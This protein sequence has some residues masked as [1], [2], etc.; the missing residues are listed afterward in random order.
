MIDLQKPYNGVLLYLAHK[1][2]PTVHLGRFANLAP[3]I[4][5][6]NACS[7]NLNA[8]VTHSNPSQKCSKFEWVGC[9]VPNLVIYAAIASLPTPMDAKPKTPTWTVIEMDAA[10]SKPKKNSRHSR[11]VENQSYNLTR[12]ST[13]I[14]PESTPHQP[15][16]NTH[17][18]QPEDTPNSHHANCTP[19][20]SRADSTFATPAIMNDHNH[21]NGTENSTKTKQAS[22]EKD[23]QGA[24]TTEPKN[25][26]DP[27]TD[28]LP[29]LSKSR[30]VLPMLVFFYFM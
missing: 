26:Y 9:V 29:Q 20:S 5:Y 13:P 24:S 3:G 30:Q 11:H 19:E 14:L 6:Q 27:E 1:E 16:S 17:F 23:I 12:E 15:E 10:C 7:D 21:G 8:T 2:S 4:K 25:L 22:Q 28:S 18:Y